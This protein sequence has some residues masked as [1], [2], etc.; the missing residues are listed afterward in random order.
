MTRHPLPPERDPDLLMAIIDLQAGIV[1]IGPDLGQVMDLVVDRVRAMAGCSGAILELVEEEELA[2]R[3]ASG[4]NQP[5]PGLR[6]KRP[7]SL[8]GLCLEAGDVL[9][10]SD[11]ETDPRVNLAACRLVGLRS[12]AVAPLLYAGAP[13][14]V[15]KLHSPEPGA[16][17]SREVQLLQLINGLIAAAL[18]H[19][20]RYGEDELYQ[21]A[22]HDAMTGLANRSLF[23]DRLRQAVSQAERQHGTLGVMIADMNGLKTIN[24]QYGHRAG[25]AAICEVARRMATVSRHADTVARLGGDEFGMILSDVGGREGAGRVMERIQEAMLPPFNFEQHQLRLN[26]SLGLALY[27]EDGTEIDTLIEKADRAMYQAKRTGK[28]TLS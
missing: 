11:S 2:C 18:F 24:D 3:A 25:D 28:P 13:V 27:A 23:Y 22:T 17:G 16:F 7:G 4:S 6:L 8:S 9:V 12:M 5:Q 26:A 15:L 19:T 10:C 1:R 20:A 21:R 14:G